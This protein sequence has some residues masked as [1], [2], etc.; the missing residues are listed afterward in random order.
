MPCRSYM[1]RGLEYDLARQ[2]A[3]ALS[4]K[5]AVRAHARDELNIDVD[6]V[7]QARVEA[8]AAAHSHYEI[9]CSTRT[10]GKRPSPA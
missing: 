7:S 1:D 9:A 5:D 3:V 2:V 10:P 8:A 4:L 6:E